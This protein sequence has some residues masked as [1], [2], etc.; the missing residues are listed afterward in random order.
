[1]GDVEPENLQQ[2]AKTM[3]NAT[4]VGMETN[5][6]TH[7]GEMVFKMQEYFSLY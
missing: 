7:S 4:I 5:S 6:G 3:Q 1:L 2:I